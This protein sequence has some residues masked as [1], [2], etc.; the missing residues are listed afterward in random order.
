M[1]LVSIDVS[2]SRSEIAELSNGIAAYEPGPPLPI[3]AG[4]GT[5]RGLNGGASTV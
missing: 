1:G 2:T 3:V 4:K 5:L